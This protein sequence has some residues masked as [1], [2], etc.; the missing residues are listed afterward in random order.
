M[1]YIIAMIIAAVIFIFVALLFF[2]LQREV[3]ISTDA[4]MYEIDY[5]SAAKLEEVANVRQPFVFSGEGL[6][7]DVFAY[8]EINHIV[9]TTG[10]VFAVSVKDS[11]DYNTAETTVPFIASPIRT[12]AAVVETDTQSRYFSDSNGEFLEEAGAAKIVAKLDTFLRPPMAIQTTHDLMFGS[13]GTCTP[14][15]YITDHAHYIAVTRGTL[16]IKLVPPNH[17]SALQEVCDYENYEFRSRVDVWNVQAIYKTAMDTVRIID[18][19]VDAGSIISIP[20]Y[21]WFSIK[22]AAETGEN[23][24]LAYT[25]NTIPSKLVNSVRISKF[26][27]QALNTT[28]VSAKRVIAHTPTTEPMAEPD[29]TAD[30]V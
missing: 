27:L 2:H 19:R 21:W 4:E 17:T 18:A 23:V 5:E 7:D 24:A 14:L 25:Y 10:G 13:H 12:V 8:A 6:A 30:I 26:A 3:R 9:K 1:E 16:D 20:P 28:T 15:R 22:F 29:S 11:R